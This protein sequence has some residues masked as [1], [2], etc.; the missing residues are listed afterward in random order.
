MTFLA[1]FAKDV[2]FKVE[3]RIFH[4]IEADYLGGMLALTAGYDTKGLM[5]EVLKKVYLVY[6]LDEDLSGYPSLTERLQHVRNAE[7]KLEDLADVFEVSKY[8][9]ALGKYDVAKSYLEKTGRDYSSR[10]IFNNMGVIGCLAALDHFKKE[11]MPYAI[12]LELDVKTR[13]KKNTRGSLS[14]SQRKM[15]RNAFLE[16]AISNFKR[17]YQLDPSYVVAYLNQGCAHFLLEDYRNAMHLAEEV[18]I[19]ESNND[20]P[21]LKTLADSYVLQGIVTILET[22]DKVKAGQLFK[23]ALNIDPYSLGKLNSEIL[24]GSLSS[25]TA[26]YDEMVA[27]E[28]IDGVSLLD[29]I[30]ENNFDYD[31]SILVNKDINL[32]VQKLGQSKIFVHEVEGNSQFIFH[33]TGN[34]YKGRT[35]KGIRIKSPVDAVLRDYFPPTKEINLSSGSLYLYPNKRLIFEIDKA[36]YVK[37]WGIYNKLQID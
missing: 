3:E 21:N 7:R 8:L 4:E 2:R 17:A 23:K 28:K 13:L 20:S 37:G 26:P 24:N 29:L 35:S 15:K 25:L 30:D 33:L 18:E 1:G 22:K 19:L 9:I 34:R 5:S 6:E 11:E 27:E 36:G 32:Y 12:P 10:E 31:N 16:E 14:L